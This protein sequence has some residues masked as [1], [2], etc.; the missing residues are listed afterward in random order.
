[1]RQIIKHLSG[2]GVKIL[3][4]GFDVDEET[5]RKCMKS[6]DTSISEEEITTRINS[7]QEFDEIFKENNVF[8]HIYSNDEEKDNFSIDLY[9]SW[10]YILQ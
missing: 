5:Q 2:N 7:N 3:S 10:N 1:M 9:N 8:E 6:R 4:F